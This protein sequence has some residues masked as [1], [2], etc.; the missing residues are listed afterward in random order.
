MITVALTGGIASGK[1]VVLDAAGSFPEVKTVQA[2][3]LA[4]EIY[5]PENPHFDEVVDLLGSKIIDEA[6]AVNREK[7]AE[8]VFENEELLCKLENIA[9]PYVRQR[10][11]GL[12]NDH[13]DRDSGLLMIEIPLLFQSPD[14]E[15]EVFDHILLVTVNREAQIERLMERD[16]ISEATAK[17]RIELQELPKDARE[18][19]D[20]V[21]ETGCSIEETRQRTRAL[22]EELLD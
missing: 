16:G 12:I 8:L 19:S 9:H 7:V 17:K 21:I 22:V 5:C 15:L 4:Q 2:D 10:I 1:T 13:R 3:K 20:F 11:N 14:A 18:K 6:G